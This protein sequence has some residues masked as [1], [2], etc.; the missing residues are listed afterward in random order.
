MLK[1][2]MPVYNFDL[3]DGIYTELIYNHDIEKHSH[4]FWEIAIT[5]KGEYTNCFDSGAIKLE[6]DTMIVIRPDDTH[7]INNLTAIYRDIYISDKKM[8]EMC[9]AISPSLYREL[10]SPVAPP[11]IKI[12]KSHI[13]SCETTAR[14][15]T[16]FRSDYQT[17]QIEPLHNILIFKAL[18]AYF[19]AKNTSLNVKIP[20]WLLD[21]VSKLNI[22]ADYTLLQE[23]FASLSTL[24]DQ[25][26]YSHGHVCRE[27]KKYFNCTPIQY[28]N[29]QKMIYSTSLLLN[30]SISVAEIAQILGYSNQSNYIMA[31]KNFYGIPPNAWRKNRIRRI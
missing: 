20:Q 13:N 28:L 18:S 29:K 25:T 4:Y 19:E 30:S 14:L 7:Y 10:K 3:I 22:T 2:D 24:I 8:R 16:E 6:P 1:N 11:Y 26:G 21:M 23:P 12:D 5:L 27:F 15:I 9:D 31:F 17:E